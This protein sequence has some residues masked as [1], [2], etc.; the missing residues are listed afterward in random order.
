VPGYPYSAVVI[1]VEGSNGRMLVSNDAL[2]LELS[3]DAG[4]YPG[5]STLI[6]EADL[7]QPARFYVNS[8][9]YYLE[10]ADFLR[11][12][13]GGPAPPITLEAAMSVQRTMAALYDSAREGGQAVRVRS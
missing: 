9:G 13:T 8:E 10:D 11:W 12:A 7:P 4:G 1:E 5:G 3:A 6:R 2:E